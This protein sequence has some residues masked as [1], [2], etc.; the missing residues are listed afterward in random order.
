MVSY[1]M[2]MEILLLLV[3][4]PWFISLRL[5]PKPST[6]CVLDCSKDAYWQR[7]SISFSNFL[8]VEISHSISSYSRKLFYVLDANLLWE[9]HRLSAPLGVVEERPVLVSVQESWCSLFIA[10]SSALTLVRSALK[11]LA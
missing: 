9:E 2:I 4:I 7:L 8:R 11:S 5:L 3:C 6:I 10:Q 1:L